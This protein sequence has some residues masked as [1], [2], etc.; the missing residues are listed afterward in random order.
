MLEREAL[1]W[2]YVQVLLDY[3]DGIMCINFFP[4]IPNMNYV[5]DI[6]LLAILNIII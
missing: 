3:V 2:N 1:M 5:D 4:L 6:L